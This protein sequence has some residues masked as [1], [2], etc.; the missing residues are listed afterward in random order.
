MAHEALQDYLSA[1]GARIRWRRARAPLLRELSDH[2]SDQA[3]DYRA[4]GQA[5]D[6]AL[7]H[8]VAEMG[9]PEAVGRELDRL[10]RPRNRWGVALAVLVLAVAGL[11]LQQA[12]CQ[13]FGDTAREDYFRR[14][15]FGLLAGCGVLLAVWF[16]DV[17]ALLRRKGWAVGTIAALW[18]LL[19]VLGRAF[20][21]RFSAL[22]FWRPPLYFT[23]VLPL[24]Y[25]AILCRLKGRGCGTILLCGAGAMLL[26]LMA[27]RAPSMI[28]Y[29]IAAAAMLLVLG[30]AVWSDWF[31]GK[32]PL[33]LLCA[34]LPALLVFLGVVCFL[35]A[36]DYYA[37]RLAAFLDPAAYQYG[38]GYLFN[39]L[40]NGLPLKLYANSLD[41]NLLLY[42]AARLYGGWVLVL[43]PAAAALA[44]LLLLRRIHRLLSRSGKL[45][46]LA[47]LWPLILQAGVYLL[48][49]TGWSPF[50]PL[51]LPFLSY[52]AGFLVIDAA[53]V[54]ALLSVFRMDALTRDVAASLGGGPR[55]RLPG[56]VSVPFGRGTLSIEYRRRAE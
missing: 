1:V 3:E 54:G 11:A 28:S 13:A 55:P 46:A 48:Y 19:A 39:I 18:L 29:L 15:V 53:L 44:A 36:T 6:A 47:A 12:V 10:H 35:R 51:S 14:Q 40:R 25:A 37:E 2:I 16:S 17:P 30:A 22:G 20:P 4:Q 27:L 33:Q 9:D 8:A 49:N 52:G 23:L 24:P 41:A 32:K 56:R 42:E 31:S 26:P 21:L 7:E 34:F 45:L 38:A 5:E 50:S 43:A